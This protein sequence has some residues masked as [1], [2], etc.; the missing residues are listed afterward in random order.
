M[1]KDEFIASMPPVPEGKKLDWV[2]GVLTLVDEPTKDD[3]PIM[4]RVKTFED[5]C[6]VLGEEHELVEQYNGIATIGLDETGDDII[7]YLKLRIIASALNEGWKP[8][9]EKGEYR[10]YP[11]FKFYTQ[12]E[13]DHL[14]DE[15][16]E[17]ISLFLWG[18]VAYYGSSC[19]LG[20]VYSYNA[21]SNSNETYGSSHAIKSEELSDYFGKQFIDIW[22]SFLKGQNLT[23]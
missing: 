20:Y 12:D 4:E 21:F 13:I 8:R 16:K 1:T 11:W 15:D 10:W 5:A 23:K 2:N 17:R 3:R 7:A 14:D 18:G 6:K 9:F 19:G 22:A